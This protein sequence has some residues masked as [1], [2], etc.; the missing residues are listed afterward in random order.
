MTKNK[1]TT[2]VIVYETAFRRIRGED[3]FLFLA[4]GNDA[5][6]Q[7]WTFR[8]CRTTL[9]T[10]SL[11]WET[12]CLSTL[13]H[14]EFNFGCTV[15]NLYVTERLSLSEIKV[16]STNVHFSFREMYEHQTI[17]DI[18]GGKYSVIQLIFIN[19]RLIQG[20][21]LEHLKALEKRFQI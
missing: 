6:K 3:T 7:S 20:N 13:I 9:K 21:A 10:T 15:G 14:L 4:T 5:R 1:S 11:S 19:R 18:G 16:T 12:F 2:N 8:Y 17:W